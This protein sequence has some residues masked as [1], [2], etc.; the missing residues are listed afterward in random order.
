MNLHNR[1]QVGHAIEVVG[2]KFTV[3]SYFN[4][5]P[6]FGDL[7]S[8]FVLN[9]TALGQLPESKGQLKLGRPSC[10]ISLV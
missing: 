2:S 8:Q 9:F 3:T 4:F 10:D 6:C 1:D 5:R 7:G